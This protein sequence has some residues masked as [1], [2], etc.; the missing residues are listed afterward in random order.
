MK[1]QILLALALFFSSIAHAQTINNA[2][3]N[4]TGNTQNVIITQTGAGHSTNLT[5]V[6]DN[7]PVSVTQS[8]STPQS[9]NLSITC[10]TNCSSNPTVV[11]QY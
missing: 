4:I 3:V 8:G 7:I 11:N 1:K 2:T 6:G 5:L 10:Y 9:F